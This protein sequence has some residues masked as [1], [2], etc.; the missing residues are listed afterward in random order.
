MAITPASA[1]VKKYG[2]VVNFCAK[3]RSETAMRKRHL[4]RG[5][6]GE[7]RKSSFT[8]ESTNMLWTVFVV[9][10]VLWALGLV[11]SYT[12]GGLIHVLLLFAVAVMLI[13]LLQGRRA[14]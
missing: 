14:V 2:A 1:I 4:D 8:K 11:T 7:M 3:R 10:V 12:L 5:V 13:R 9:L 6:Q